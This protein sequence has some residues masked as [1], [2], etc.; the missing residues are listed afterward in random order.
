MGLFDFFKKK[1]QGI[2]ENRFYSAQFQTEVCALALWKLK[3][4]NF[5]PAEAIKELKQVGLN[6]EQVDF[7]LTKTNNFLKQD[8]ELDQQTPGIEEAKFR[9]SEFRKEILEFAQSTYFQNNHSYEVVAQKL[10]EKGLNRS[11]ANTIVSDLKNLNADM[12]ADFQEKLDSGVISDIK[13]KPSADHTKGNVSQDQVDRYIA[14]GAYQLERGDL[15]N[16]LE[17]F[18]K[19]LE[20]DDKAALAYANKGNLY[21]QKDENDKALQ[22][23]NKA[24]ELEPNHVKIL[25]N[26]MN[27]LFE[28]MTEANEREFIETVKGILQ[29]EP[30]H[31]NALIY[32]IQHYLKENDIENAFKSAKKLFANYHSE[33]MAI[34][35]LL[36]VI[37][38][39][40]PE[41]ALREFADFKV[42]LSE[43]A[44][45]QLEYCKGLYLLAL[46]RYDEA[47]NLFEKLNQLQEFSWNYY[48]MAIA[49]NFQNKTE[50]TLKLLEQTFKLEPELKNDAKQFPHLQNLWDH[51]Q[52]I[53]LTK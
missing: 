5:N 53:A 13:I 41:R 28:T 21:Y 50:E 31:P 25:E 22:F 3:E 43:D 35:L 36:D 34:H 2:E 33:T 7:I 6:D 38:K 1:Q 16:A 10:L 17:L 4:N 14:Y 23:Y 46:G 32:I 40:P 39:F 30:E 20:L 51:P 24:L 49:H 18:D 26:K 27:L 52:F 48:Q 45:Y 11:Q 8:T 37:H 12:V 47:I 44:Q 29:N 42:T 9:S 19:A 15:D